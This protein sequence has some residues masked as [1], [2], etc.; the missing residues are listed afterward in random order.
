MQVHKFDHDWHCVHCGASQVTMQLFESTA[1]GDAGH[2]KA[3]RQATMQ[4]KHSPPERPKIKPG[5]AIAQPNTGRVSAGIFTDPEEWA[6]KIIE[7]KSPEEQKEAMARIG[8][9]LAKSLADGSLGGFEVGEATPEE[10]AAGLVAP[11]M[12]IDMQK[13]EG[14]VGYINL[15][16]ESLRQFL[17]LPHGVEI[18]NATWDY[19]YNS[20]VLSLKG[21]G[22]PE[23]C[24]RKYQDEHVTEVFPKYHE[25]VCYVYSNGFGAMIQKTRTSFRFFA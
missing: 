10:I 17:D 3:L 1:C 24:A 9:K 25:A 5:D 6:K 8:E 4:R 11:D 12:E 23:K 20:V 21:E 2:I 19:R 18:T 16:A 22:L 7:S 14:R 13:P 15:W